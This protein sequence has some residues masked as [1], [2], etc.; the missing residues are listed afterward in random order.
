MVAHVTG[1]ANKTEKLVALVRRAKALKA[2]ADKAEAEARKAVLAAN[3]LTGLDTWESDDGIV[4]L[5]P[6]AGKSGFDKDI[7]KKYL[8]SEQYAECVTHGAPT[9]QLRFT[10][11]ITMPDIKAA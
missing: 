10:M 1:M 6:V 8:T 4:K 9:V 7:A 5:S 11:P 2:E 3:E